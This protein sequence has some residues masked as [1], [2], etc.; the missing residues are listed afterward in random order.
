MHVF[1]IFFVEIS[2][3]VEKI[4]KKRYAIYT[5]VL[6]GVLF[7]RIYPRN[8]RRIVVF[9]HLYGQATVPCLRFYGGWHLYVA[10]TF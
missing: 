5:Y 2:K 6:R 10:Q 3:Y 7:V 4:N 1:R 9:A 8:T